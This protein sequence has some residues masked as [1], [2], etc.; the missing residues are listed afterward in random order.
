MYPINPYHDIGEFEKAIA[1]YTGAPYVVALDS[2]SSGMFLSLTYEDIKGKVISI[3]SRTYMSVPCDIIHAGGIVEFIPMPEVPL[4][5]AYPLIGSKTWDSA[6][7]FTADMYIPDTFMCC[8]FTGSTKILKLG[9]GGCILTDNKDAYEWFKKT[10]FSGREECSYHNQ[11]SFNM[12]GWNFYFN[13]MLATL[14]L[15]LM[16]QFYNLDG[17]KKTIP[18]AENMYPDLSIYPIYKQ[19]P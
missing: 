2:C 8:S 11:K 13:P 1:D 4:K 9:K 12:L 10:R 7:R 5:G 18:D 15:M 16:G 17:S 14:G 19:K 3:P 6:L